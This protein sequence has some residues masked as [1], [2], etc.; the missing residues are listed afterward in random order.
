M[1]RRNPQCMLALRATA[2]ELPSQT[3]RRDPADISERRAEKSNADAIGHFGVSVEKRELRFHL[4]HHATCHF[5]TS[6]Q[7]FEKVRIRKGSFQVPSASSSFFAWCVTRSLEALW[8][9]VPV[10]TVPVACSMLDDTKLDK[11]KG[12]ETRPKNNQ[13]INQ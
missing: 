8:L 12:P 11:R 13:S 10:H 9:L 1:L 2:D 3:S 7:E 5:C 4:G 6:A